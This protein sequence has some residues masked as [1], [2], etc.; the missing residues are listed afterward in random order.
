MNDVSFIWVLGI[1]FL[2]LVGQI[3][4]LGRKMSEPEK[5]MQPLPPEFN[6]RMEQAIMQYKEWLDS[7]NLSYLTSFQFGMI[8]VVVYQQENHPRFFSFYFHKKLTFDIE[9]YLEDLT[10]LDTATSGSSGLFPRPRAYLQSLPNL[11]AQEAWQKHIEAEEYLS[12]KFGYDWKPLKKPYEQ[13]LQDAVRLR[14]NYNRSQS[15]W[16]IR[17]LYRFFVTRHLINN[18]TIAQQ[19]P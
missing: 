4:F 10:I 16:P 2:V 1:T 9:S 6:S 11:S 17:V 8:S 12:K 19:F 18:R 14:M 15:F 5:M 13:M 7:V 3:Y